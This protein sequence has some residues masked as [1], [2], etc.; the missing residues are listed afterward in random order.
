MANGNGIYKS[1]K[2]QKMSI[3]MSRKAAIVSMYQDVQ[4]L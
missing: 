1:T 3:R 4:V 2:L